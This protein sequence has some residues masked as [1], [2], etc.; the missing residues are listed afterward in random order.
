MSL[1]FLRIFSYILQKSLYIYIKF[2]YVIK[3]YILYINIFFQA[4][5]SIYEG[6]NTITYEQLLKQSEAEKK[7]DLEYNEDPESTAIVLYTSGSTGTPKGTIH[8]FIYNSDKFQIL[9]I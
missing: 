6:T 5:A 4:D 8:L 2:Y 1:S 3:L 9:R 7:E